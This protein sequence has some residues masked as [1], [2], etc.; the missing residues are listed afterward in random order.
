MSGLPPAPER[1]CVYTCLF[2]GYEALNEQEVAGASALDFIC[3]TDDPHLTSRS[4]RMVLIEPLLPLD[5]VRSQRRV[6]FGAHTL[7]PDYDVSL[8]L[9][10]SIVLK[11]PPEQILARHLGPDTAAV[12][13]GHSFRASVADEFLEILR[14]GLDDANRIIEQMNHYLLC[15]P[16]VME[17]APYWSGLM[18]RRHHRPEVIA[19]MELWFAHVLRYSRR[20]QVSGPLAFRQ[21]GLAVERLE[22]DNLDSWFHRWP[23]VRHRDRSAFPFSPHLGQL[24]PQMLTREWKRQIQELEARNAEL[25]ARTAELEARLAESQAHAATL[26]GAL[27][28]VKHAPQPARLAPGDAP[29]DMP[30]GLALPAGSGRGF[31]RA[32]GA[33]VRSRLPGG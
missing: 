11:V 18:I 32:L 16:E 20:D 29:G 23:V 24:P 19:A 21:A 30:G 22:I 13:P 7:L 17:A 12:F 33:F 5:P 3:F 2:G 14:L 25:A 31:A 4:W 6:K 9:D 10:N 8:Y 26:E 1:A 27:A 15:H 28:D